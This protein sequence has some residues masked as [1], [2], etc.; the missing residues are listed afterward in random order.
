MTLTSGPSEVGEAE[1]HGCYDFG[2][3]S[4]ILGYPGRE[5]SVVSEAEV[6]VETMHF[7]SAGIWRIAPDNTADSRQ[8]IGMASTELG[9]V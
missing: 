1:S 7:D 2:K 3:G 4:T 8:G 9:G 6:Q 5:G